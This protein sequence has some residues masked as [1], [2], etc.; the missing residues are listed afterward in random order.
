MSKNYYMI[1]GVPSNATLEEIKSA[2]RRRARDL[3]PDTSGME[4][5][6]F[7]EVQEAYSVLADP[8]QRE[9]FD[10]QSR[11]ELAVPQRSWRP[12]A[13]PLRAPRPRVEGLKS[14]LPRGQSHEELFTGEFGEFRPSFD[15]LFDRW[16]NNFRP[17]SR[18][19][20]ERLESLT[21]EIVLTADQALEGGSIRLGIP[22]RT[23][24]PACRGNGAVGAYECWRCE[25][26]GV[27]AAQYPVSVAYPPG[28]RSEYVVRIP[29]TDYGISN[30]YLTVLFRV[31][32]D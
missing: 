20:A 17:V 14:V 7:L 30:F 3:H 10:Q 32:D 26:H 22:A 11:L 27:L 2:F 16:W 5:D 31:S 23:K 24:C 8:E 15:E 29:L 13:E 18:P 12:R 28:I 21:V 25:G 4:S 6:P 19:K 1:L 9:R